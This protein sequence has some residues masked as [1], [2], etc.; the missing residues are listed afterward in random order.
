M[1]TQVATCA[2]LTAVA[3]VGLGMTP[4][5]AEGTFDRTV[6]E[7]PAEFNSWRANCDNLRAALDG[8]T[9]AS[10]GKTYAVL[11]EPSI[12][13]CDDN[14]V[15]VK[16]WITVIG[17]GPQATLITG[18]ADSGDLGV[19]NMRGNS[20]IK[21]L[22][23]RNVDPS[24]EPSG[25]AISVRPASP[26]DTGAD[27]VVINYV[28]AVSDDD[29]AVAV[30][31]CSTVFIDGSTLVG[32]DEALLLESGDCEGDDAN[33]S[34]AHGWLIGDDPVVTLEAGTTAGFVG[35]GWE[36]LD[37]DLELICDAEDCDNDGGAD[38][39]DCTA[40]NYLVED[41]S[42]AFDGAEP[43]LCNQD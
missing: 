33:V 17:S 19:V 7:S 34:V 6:I 9:D 18:T 10:S 16:S 40:S 5:L 29:I 37:E 35:N 41:F 8:I 4:A 24:V 31:P 20:A 22:T 14:A 21:A 32:D 12:Y 39:A 1:K 43:G 36:T 13:R 23:V 25:F 15:I 11:V 26:N 42:R 28:T 2:L 38:A 3:V 30:G 27:G